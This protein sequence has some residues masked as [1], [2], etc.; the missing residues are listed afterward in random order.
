MQQLFDAVEKAQAALNPDTK[1]TPIDPKLVPS[2]LFGRR[3][4]SSGRLSVDLGERTVQKSITRVLDWRKTII[5]S[6][7]KRLRR[8]VLDLSIHYLPSKS[9]S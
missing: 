4:F 7:R 5:V 9:G 1:A 8:T 3:R 6:E 2:R